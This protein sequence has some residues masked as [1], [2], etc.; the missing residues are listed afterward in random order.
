MLIDNEEIKN[1]GILAVIRFKK[2]YINL[3][4]V[5]LGS[6]LFIKIIKVINVIKKIIT[7]IL[8]ISSKKIFS[9]LNGYII[10]LNSLPF[11]EIKPI[12]VTI[13]TQSFDE[14]T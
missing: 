12:L 10:Y 4:K 2:F 14:I 13:A 7:R 9:P 3:L 5:K 6:N 11:S 8:K 1:G